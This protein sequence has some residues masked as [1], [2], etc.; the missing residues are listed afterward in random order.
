[1]LDQPSHRRP[2]VT[3]KA[4]NSAMDTMMLH[5]ARP[6]MTSNALLPAQHLRPSANFR[7]A[8]VS[9][10]SDELAVSHRAA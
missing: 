4:R 10:D 3:T 1:M 6:R 9:A 2:P 8:F 5:T 7:I